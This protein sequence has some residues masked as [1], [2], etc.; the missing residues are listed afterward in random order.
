[1]KIANVFFLDHSNDDE[2]VTVEISNGDKWNVQ[3]TDARYKTSLG[4]LLFKNDEEHAIDYT[5]DNADEE[6]ELAELII[7]AA[8]RFAQKHDAESFDYIDAGFNCTIN[9]T[10]IIIKVDLGSGAASVFS[11]NIGPAQ[12]YERELSLIA[13]FNDKKSAQEFCDSFKIDQ[14]ENASGLYE[15]LR[16]AA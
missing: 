14:H 1:M 6:E 5:V 8:E 11:D 12:D 15:L 16:R 4:C 9:S 10:R 3:L 2:T 13:N 7:K